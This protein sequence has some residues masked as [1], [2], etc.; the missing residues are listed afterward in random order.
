MLNQSVSCQTSNHQHP[1]IGSRNGTSIDGLF[2]GTMAPPAVTAMPRVFPR[3]AACPFVE[4]M[5]AVAGIDPVAG[6]LVARL[7]RPGRNLTGLSILVSQLMPH[8]DRRILSD[9]H[10]FGS[11]RSYKSRG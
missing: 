3:Y 2:G 4:P 1:P 8:T 5:V 10:V 7:A 6:G 9:R 11:R